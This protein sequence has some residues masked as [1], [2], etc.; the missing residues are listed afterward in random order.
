MF[1]AVLSSESGYC[2]AK[3][4]LPQGKTYTVLPMHLPLVLMLLPQMNS[5]SDNQTTRRQYGRTLDTAA[6]QGR[7]AAL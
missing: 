3:L 1:R 6:A 4:F 7:C 2:R 5:F